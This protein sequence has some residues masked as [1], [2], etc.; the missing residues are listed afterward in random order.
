MARG[1][2]DI[3]ALLQHSDIGRPPGLADL[4]DESPLESWIAG[5]EF[6]ILFSRIFENIPDNASCF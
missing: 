2:I 5:I 1:R 3:E 4:Q 6:N